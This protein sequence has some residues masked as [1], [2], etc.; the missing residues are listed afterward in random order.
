MADIPTSQEVVEYLEGYCVDLSRITSQWITNRI[1]NLVV[2]MV[3][4]ILRTEVDKELQVTE[5]HNGEGSTVLILNRRNVKSIDSIKIITNNFSNTYVSIENIELMSAEGLLK[6]K[7]NFE[8]IYGLYPIFPRG[9]K[10]IK[11]TYTLKR[12]L[13]DASIHEAIILLTCDVILGFIGSQT[14]GG[15]SFS[16]QSYSRNYGDRGKWTDV[17]REMVRQAYGLMRPYMTGVIGS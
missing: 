14:G 5:I 3:N 12:P 13:D 6:A 1:N 10:N 7:H 2:P 9:N 15:P 17:R 16:M 4:R 8:E 11:I